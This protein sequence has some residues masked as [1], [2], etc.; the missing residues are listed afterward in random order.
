[1]SEFLL[2]SPRGREMFSYLPGYYETSRVMQADMNTKG[3]EM[4]L[5]F[6]ALDETFQQFFVRTATWGLDRW[7]SE[8]GITTDLS[9][10]LDQRRAVVES[11][12][13]GSGKFSGRLVKNVAEAYDRGRVEVSFQPGEW[14]VTVKFVDTVGIPPNLDDLKAAIEELKPAHLKME[15]EFNYMLIRDV[16]GVL[17]LHELEQIPL[18]KFAGGDPVG[19]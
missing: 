8:L 5:L 16:H 6:A 18:N 19:N 2:T 1:M 13:R 14:G 4:D 12:L 15:F 10:P 11:K 7:E 17:T 9:K 3:A